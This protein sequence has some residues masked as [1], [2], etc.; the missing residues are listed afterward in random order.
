[1][2]KNANTQNFAYSGDNKINNEEL[3]NWLKTQTA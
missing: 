1:M 2:I 3:F